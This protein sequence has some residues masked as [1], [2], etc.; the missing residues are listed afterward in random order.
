MY[1][2]GGC[3]DEGSVYSPVHLRVVF[4]NDRPIRQAVAVP[5]RVESLEVAGAAVEEILDGVLRESFSVEER[6][7]RRRMAA[8]AKVRDERVDQARFRQAYLLRAARVW[9][10]GR[11]RLFRRCCCCCF[12]Q[13]TMMCVTIS[14]KYSTSR[15]YNP[16]PF[17]SVSTFLGG[18]SHGVY[19]KTS[20]GTRAPMRDLPSP[21]RGGSGGPG[22]LPG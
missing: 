12:A 17:A 22:N 1:E 8:L 10:S 15:E 16:S 14:A 21:W 13:R 3:Q 18:R 4:G 9:R 20:V 5:G 11:C 19:R 2:S 7:R 6:T